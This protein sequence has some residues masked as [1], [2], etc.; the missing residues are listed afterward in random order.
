MEKVPLKILSLFPSHV[1][2]FEEYGTYPQFLFA[3]LLTGERSFTYND[4]YKKALREIIKI[5]IKIMSKQNVEKAL[6][7]ELQILNEV[8]DRKIVRGL[9]YSR[10]SKRHKFVLYSLDNLRR[11]KQGWMMRALRPLSFV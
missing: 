3:R 11:Q 2:I 10:E 9:S 5:I 7:K 4:L 6:K 8:I 1:K